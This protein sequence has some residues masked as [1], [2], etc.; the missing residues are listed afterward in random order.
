MSD[1]ARVIER[2]VV[3]RRSVRAE[4][5]IERLRNGLGTSRGNEA[6]GRRREDEE[7][8][9]RLRIVELLKWAIPDTK[10]LDLD[11]MAH[12]IHALT[13]RFARQMILEPDD[14]PP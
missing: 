5:R 12:A 4:R 2:K 8:R 6:V 13:Q 3:A 1:P 9:R 7:G 11:L 14:F 10:G